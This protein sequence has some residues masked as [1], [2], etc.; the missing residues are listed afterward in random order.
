[1]R[2]GQSPIADFYDDAKK[3][4][5]IRTTKT[6]YTEMTRVAVAP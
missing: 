1:M 3:F 2:E 5:D 6:G 4:N